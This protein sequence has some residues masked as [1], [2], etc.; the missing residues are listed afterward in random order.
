VTRVP[1]PAIINFP[2]QGENFLIARF[3][4]LQGREKF[5]DPCLGGGANGSKKWRETQGL[6]VNFPTHPLPRAPVR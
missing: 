1:E 5:P 4:S 3:N 2:D 6:T